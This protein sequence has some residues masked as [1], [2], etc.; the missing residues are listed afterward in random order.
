M[1][2][3]VTPFPEAK[4][5]PNAQQRAVRQND[6]AGFMQRAAVLERLSNI[7]SFDWPMDRKR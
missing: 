2:I 5:K 1:L 3:G 6:Y 7:D 4:Q